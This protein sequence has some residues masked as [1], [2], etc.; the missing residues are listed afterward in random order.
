M[1]P[2]LAIAT[3]LSTEFNRLNIDLDALKA[4]NLSTNPLFTT[5]AKCQRA[6]QGAQKEPL[7]K[8]PEN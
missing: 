2:A 5:E 4:H 7:T 3:Y 8:Q 1:R 6:A